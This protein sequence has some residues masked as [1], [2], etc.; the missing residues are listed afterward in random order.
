MK[1]FEIWSWQPP[2]WKEA[3]PAVIVSHPDRAAGKDMVEI[4][5]C[6]TQR[7]TRAPRN[8]E[9]I[10]DQAEGLDWPT[11]CKCDLIWA[12]PREELKQHRGVVSFTRRGPLV[13]TMIGAHGWDD[14]LSWA[15]V[16]A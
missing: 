1:V 11:L 4:L 7:A 13:R 3:H 9:F 2:H 6:S 12:V 16:R 8:H 5:M 14:I 10:L 15:A